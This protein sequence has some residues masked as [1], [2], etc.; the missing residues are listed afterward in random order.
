MYIPC[1]KT[2]FFGT[3]VKKKKKMAILEALVFHKHS[4]FYLFLA[5]SFWS[6]LSLYWYNYDS[7]YNIL[8]IVKIKETILPL[9]FLL[10]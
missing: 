2:L 1:G 4:L 10:W 7:L 3:M 5:G 9:S 8:L 6:D